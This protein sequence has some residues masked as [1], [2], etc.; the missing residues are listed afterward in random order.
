MK[1][2][3]HSSVSSKCMISKDYTNSC[4]FDTGGVGRGEREIKIRILKYLCDKLFVK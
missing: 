1:E 3:I 2:V 4:T